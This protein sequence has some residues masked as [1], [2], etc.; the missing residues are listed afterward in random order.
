M[1]G[2][3]SRAASAMI[4][5]RRLMKKASA[6]IRSAPVR[7][8]AKVANA[9][10]ISSMVRA[11]QNMELQSERPCC[12]LHLSHFVLGKGSIGRVRKNRDVRDVWHQFVQHFQ[13]LRY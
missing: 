3:A 1:V 11:F 13:S 6:L 7:T 4:C 10:S 12:I 5:S 2:T 9:V 8:C